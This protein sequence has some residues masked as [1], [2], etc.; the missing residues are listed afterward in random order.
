LGD[1]PI[2]RGCQGRKMT[3]LGLVVKGQTRKFTAALLEPLKN[4]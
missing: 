4:P 3:S 2:N 1:D